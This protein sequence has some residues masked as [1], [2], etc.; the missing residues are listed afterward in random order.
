M[1]IEE[2]REQFDLPRLFAFTNYSKSN[3]PLHI[4]VARYLGIEQKP[5]VTEKQDEKNTNDDLAELLNMFPM[6]PQY[7]F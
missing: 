1:T 7:E 5:T 2:V 6:I 3:P 4:M